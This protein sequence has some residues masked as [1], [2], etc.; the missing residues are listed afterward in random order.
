MDQS[1]VR[2]T[3][4][5]SGM[6][7]SVVMTP[8]RHPVVRSAR[9]MA[10]VSTSAMPRTPCTPPTCGRCTDANGGGD[11]AMWV[12]VRSVRTERPIELIEFS[13]GLNVKSSL[14]RLKAIFSLPGPQV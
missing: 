9:V 10:R 6:E 5:A 13:D 2:A 4:S 3:R 8:F 12:V 11:V 1:L 7:A 14:S